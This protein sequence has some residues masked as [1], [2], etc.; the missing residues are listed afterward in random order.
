MIWSRRSDGEEE[1]E[2]VKRAL[3]RNK[4]SGR[5]KRKSVSTAIQQLP[6]PLRYPLNPIR[7]FAVCMEDLPVCSLVN[8]LFPLA[9]MSPDFSS[10]PFSAFFCLF[11]LVLWPPPLLPKACIQNVP[12]STQTPRG[13]N[14][15]TVF[16]STSTAIPYCTFSALFLRPA[17]AYG[18]YGS[19]LV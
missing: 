1:E 13:A 6:H 17:S 14:H 15:I 10:V 18:M 5:K 4:F 11:S 9:D 8:S 3:E 19:V 12:L 2:E 7:Q 16:S